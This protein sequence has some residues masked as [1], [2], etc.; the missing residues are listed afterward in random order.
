[1]DIV[2]ALHP[3]ERVACFGDR[4]LRLRAFVQGSAATARC[5]PD[6]AVACVDGPAWLTGLGGWQSTVDTQVDVPSIGGPQL[7]LEPGGPVAASALPESGMVD[8]EGAFDHPAA[9]DCRAGCDRTRSTA[10]RGTSSP[11]SPAG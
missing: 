1:M 7:T 5:V 9:T 6:P 11:A 2:A 3:E 8:L 10:S 4:P